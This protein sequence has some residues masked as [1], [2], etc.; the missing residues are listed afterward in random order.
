MEHLFQQNLI[1]LAIAMAIV[2]LKPVFFKWVHIP[3]VVLEVL[4][5]I[6]IGPHVLGFVHPHE[7]ILFL[8]KFGSV[9]LFFMAGYEISPDKIKGRPIINALLGWILSALLAASV[10]FWLVTHDYASAWLLTGLALTTTAIGALLPILRDS[11]QLD[12]PYGPIVLAAGASG[13][14]LPIIAMTIITT[15][16]E[17][18]LEAAIIFIFII[19]SLA[20]IFI[21]RRIR[22]G[23]LA[24]IV[25]KTIEH[26]AQFP[27]RLAFC[28]LMLLVAITEYLEI[29]AILGA[30]I[31]GAVIRGAF[32]REYDAAISARLDGIGSS[33]LV[34]I[35]FL[36]SGAQLD[37]TELF[38][39]L[40]VLIMAPV[41]ALSMLLVRGVPA[42]LLYGKDLT[43]RRR[44]GLA[45]HLGTQLPMVVIIT[46]IA[47]QRDLMSSTQAAQLVSGAI[48]TM[49]FYPALSRRFLGPAIQDS[50]LETT[51]ANSAAAPS[52]HLY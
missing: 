34:P 10:S 11:R 41:Y 8:A 40:E 29:D 46:H 28:I 45:L 42:L 32:Q 6:I 36:I 15:Q 31:A 50:D 43:L 37:V 49:L 26:S 20:L 47:T 5:G 4:L 35:F 44:C 2:A 48:L 1:A 33:L 7:I 27:V 14:A 52:Q 18:K 39:N 22:H 16:K 3:V 17:V 9:I 25:E 19:S 51:D 38:S 13:E 30:F 23:R 12:P 24:K 21:A